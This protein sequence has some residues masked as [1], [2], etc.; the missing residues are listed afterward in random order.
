[1]PLTKS[2]N[3]SIVKLNKEA[4]NLTS[5]YLDEDGEALMIQLETDEEYSG[6]AKHLLHVKTYQKRLKEMRK[7]VTGPFKDALAEVDGHF[8]TALSVTE[9]VESS[10]KDGMSNYIAACVEEAQ[11]L[12]N[13]AVANKDSE[14]LIEA[15]NYSQPPI[16]GISTRVNQQVIITDK[17]A[18]PRE[19]LKVDESAIKRAA[20]AGV[21]IP[22][23]EVVDRP[24]I[25]VTVK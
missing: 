5:E 14:A 21:K 12:M 8:K 23:V 6:I 11:E 20:K 2:Q 10:I 1:M 18:I 25:A 4:G 17:E 16:S 24:L 19:F 3:T 22:G 13:E 15:A 7:A 9:K